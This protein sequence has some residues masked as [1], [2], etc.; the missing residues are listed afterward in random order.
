MNTTRA[1]ILH[2]AEQCV[3]SDRNAV[4]GAPEYNFALIAKLWAIYT[5][6]SFNH[7]DVAAMMILLKL[8][9]VKT[10]PNVE[11]H[12]VDIAGYAACGAEV[13]GL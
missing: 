6:V 4:Y 12:W 13:S 5:G 1:R 11:D 8:A 7:R 2:K 9:R 10:S 3:C